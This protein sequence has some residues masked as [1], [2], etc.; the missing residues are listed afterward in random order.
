[1]KLKI[2]IALLIGVL[3]GAFAYRTW[4]VRTATTRHWTAVR[5]YSAYMRDPANY[6]STGNGHTMASEPLDPE[7]H[8]AALVSAGELIHDDIVFPSVP[9]PNR[10]FTKHWMAFCERHPEEI[11]F[12]YGECEPG[13]NHLK[14]WFT[15]AGRPLLEQLITELKTIGPEEEP[16]TH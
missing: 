6:K 15:D 4:D 3:I 5:E 13:P 9:Y 12:A 10:A 1:M 7:P 16:T 2:A 11:V 14:F 8:L